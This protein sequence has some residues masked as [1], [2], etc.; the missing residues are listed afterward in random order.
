MKAHEIEGLLSLILTVRKAFSGPRRG[1]LVFVRA[2]QEQKV[3]KLAIELAQSI[4]QS[5]PI[6]VYVVQ[7]HLRGQHG[8]PFSR[9]KKIPRLRLE[10]N[11]QIVTETGGLI[12]PQDRPIILLVEYFDCLEPHDQQ[13]YAHLVDGEGG[14]WALHAGSVL[15]GALLANTPGQLEA[16]LASR[17]AHF[18]LA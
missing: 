13:A 14:E 2:D 6:P 15:I 17:G 8:W 9:I 7:G 3:R 1:A 10:P 16:S 18:S 4:S 12:F 5:E 11:G